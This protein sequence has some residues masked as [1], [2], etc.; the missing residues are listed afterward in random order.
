LMMAGMAPAQNMGAVLPLDIIL[1]R[2][3]SVTIHQDSL[4]AHTKYKVKEEVIFSE[5]T[6]QGTIKNSDTVISA[7]TI[8]D[9]K[10]LSREL[11]Y[12]TKKNKSE[13]KKEQSQSGEF[14]LDFNNPDYNYSLTETNDSSYII[15]VAP[16]L[17]PK[18]GD[19]KGTFEI[20]RKGFFIKA[21]DASVPKPEGAL[22]EFSTWMSFE[23]MEGGLVVI[24]DV[25][26]NG[27]A[28]ALFGIIKIRFSGEVRYSNYE[29]LK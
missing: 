19:F 18:K 13:D 4:L 21:I 1:H 8:A 12:S 14:S 17:S 9:N 6:N 28:K 27:L 3:D 5:L 26:M 11:L 22:K 25:K 23:P 29:I 7:V 15:A 10:E 16:K 2:A 24:K 20:D